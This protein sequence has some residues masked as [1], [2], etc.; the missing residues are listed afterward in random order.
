M[1]VIDVDQLNNLKEDFLSL[2][3]LEFTQKSDFALE[4]FLY[5]SFDLYYFN[6]RRSFPNVG[7]QIDDS[8]EFAHE[9]YLNSIIDWY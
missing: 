8:F 2:E 3:Q 4:K 7:E 5:Q 9:I 1:R 6:S